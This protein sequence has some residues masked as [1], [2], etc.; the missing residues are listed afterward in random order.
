M[1]FIT[2]RLPR[3]SIRTRLNRNFDFDL[4]NN[5]ASNSVFFCERLGLEVYEELGHRAFLQRLKDG[6][7]RQL[8]FFIHGFS[9]LPEDVFAATHELQ[10]LCEATEPKEVLLTHGLAACTCIQSKLRVRPRL[11]QPSSSQMCHQLSYSGP[12][13]WARSRPHL[14]LL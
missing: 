6:K 5:A 2:N 4:S 8:L 7:Y 1:L 9:T 13:R 3:Q 14:S 12:A 11:T 10:A